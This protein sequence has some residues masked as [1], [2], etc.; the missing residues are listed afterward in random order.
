MVT[1][2]MAMMIDLIWN[3]FNDID[4]DILVFM[5]NCGGHKTA[6]IEKL[7]DERAIYVALFVC[8]DDN[9]NI[10]KNVFFYAWS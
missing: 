8:G 10:I 9:N 7:L 5:D 2:R 6:A 1:V 4:E 3:P